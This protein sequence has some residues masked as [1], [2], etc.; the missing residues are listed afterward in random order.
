VLNSAVI[1]RLERCCGSSAADRLWIVPS[2]PG[3]E[4]IDACFAGPAYNSRLWTELSWFES[5]SPSQSFSDKPPRRRREP[6]TGKVGAFF[7]SP[8]FS[9]IRHIKAAS[10]WCGR[11]PMPK[12]LLGDLSKLE[13]RNRGLEK[14]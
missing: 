13:S 6:A 7:D 8:A 9:A 2:R 10:G 4:R 14:A 3:L 1:N 11:I 5:R 12:H